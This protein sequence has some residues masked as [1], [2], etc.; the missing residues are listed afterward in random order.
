MTRGDSA[1]SSENE[2]ES[3]ARIDR[4]PAG[5]PPGPTRPGR[6]LISQGVTYGEQRGTLTTKTMQEWVDQV[7]RG[8]GALMHGDL[9]ELPEKARIAMDHESA[10]LSCMQEFQNAFLLALPKREWPYSALPT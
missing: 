6:R 8:A 10:L 2:K 1:G 3:H 4:R 5:A 9:S 7:D